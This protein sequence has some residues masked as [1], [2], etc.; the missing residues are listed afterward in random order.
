M[1]KKQLNI[2]KDVFNGIDSIKIIGPFDLIDTQIDTI[3]DEIISMGK[4]GIV[5]DF[6]ETTYF[7]SSGL[8]IL[9]KALKKLQNV[10]GTLYIANTTE[11]MNDFLSISS[12]DRFIQ[13]L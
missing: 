1:I 10:E 4:K 9:I 2:K 5:F 3:V 11:D 12:L 7:T 6:K 13:Y 8:A